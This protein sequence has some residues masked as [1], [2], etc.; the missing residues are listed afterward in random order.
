MTAPQTH[1][2]TTDGIREAYKATIARRAVLDPNDLT[3]ASLALSHC[4]DLQRI[5]YSLLKTRPDLAEPL[6]RAA[7]SVKVV[8]VRL[9]EE[10]GKTLGSPGRLP[11]DGVVQ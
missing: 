9:A 1:N 7:A 5:A 4:L 3:C 10:S 8:L 2:R 6:E 11:G